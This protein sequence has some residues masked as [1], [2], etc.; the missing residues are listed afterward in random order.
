MAKEWARP[1]RHATPA[2]HAAPKATDDAV[3]AVALDLRNASTMHASSG[4][5]A[6][7]GAL[8][9]VYEA[10]RRDRGGAADSWP[11]GGNTGS[12][13]GSS[14]DWNKGCL[15]GRAKS[16]HEGRSEGSPEDCPK[17]CAEGCSEG[18]PEDCTEGRSEGSPDDCGGVGG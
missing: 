2:R 4:S 5:E 16:R 6:V 14:G 17:G 12:S 15:E 13:T 10:R 1:S 8:R 11:E 3:G 9:A 18:S 7:R